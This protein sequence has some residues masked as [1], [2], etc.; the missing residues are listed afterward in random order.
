[1]SRRPLTPEELE[2]AKRLR[3]LW[4]ER[5]DQFHLS[6]VKAA[7]E[8]GFSS[9]AAVSQYLNARVPLN[10]KTVAK[11]AK[12]LR[13]NVEEISPRFGKL[14]G[15]PMP[16]ELEGYQ[17]AETGSLNG[18]PTNLCVDWFAFSGEF[19]SSLGVRSLKAMRLEDNSNKDYPAGTILLVDDSHQGVAA[20]G[21]YLLAQGNDIILRR[22]TIDADGVT[23]H[24]PKKLKLNKDAFGLLKILARVVAEFRKT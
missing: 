9:Q 16:A 17:R 13:L 6:Q 22:I 21:L 10:V 4:N 8:M 11:F 12:L 24:G 23:I 20:D 2:D 1:M 19:V 14:V 3:K 18:V 7:D 5:K 15:K